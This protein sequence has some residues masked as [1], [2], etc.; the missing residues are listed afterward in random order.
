MLYVACTVLSLSR[1]KRP[2]QM[3]NGERGRQDDEELL[4][5][6]RSTS[7]FMS[8]MKPKLIVFDSPIYEK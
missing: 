6:V 8:N 1:F 4:Q 5:S 2:I 3:Q 7:S